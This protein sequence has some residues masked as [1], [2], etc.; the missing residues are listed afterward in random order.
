MYSS[1]AR[2]GH[3]IIIIIIIKLLNFRAL[4]SKYRHLNALRVF[5]IN[6]FKSIINFHSIMDTVGIRMSTR[7]IREFS[8]F[9]VSKVLRNSPSARCVIP[10][11][12][13]RRFSR[14]LAKT[15]SPLRTLSLYGESKVSRLIICFSLI[16]FYSVSS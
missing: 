10:S 7:Q 3:I 13:I 11:C 2:A 6:V 14:Y 15:M 4:Y 5:L 1:L 12:D 9:S 16:L 8:T